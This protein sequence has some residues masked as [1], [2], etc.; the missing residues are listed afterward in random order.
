MYFILSNSNNTSQEMYSCKTELYM[1]LLRRAVFHSST[2]LCIQYI[3]VKTHYCH[4]SGAFDQFQDLGSCFRARDDLTPLSSSVC[5]EQNSKF[6]KRT[7]PF[8]PRPRARD[9]LQSA[10][11]TCLMPLS[12]G[13]SL[14][15]SGCRVTLHASRT[16]LASG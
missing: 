10:H 7:R 8:H 6:T 16:P 14:R 12:S 1:S 3:H 13:V 9:H 5:I 2:D 15:N 11:R 4:S